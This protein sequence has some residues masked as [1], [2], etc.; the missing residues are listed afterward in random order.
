MV[1]SGLLR[2]Q[3]MFR[4]LS[5]HR[6]IINKWRIYRQHKYMKYIYAGR[7]MMQHIVVDSYIQFSVLVD[8]NFFFL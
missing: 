6:A 5:V 2:S 4:D 7:K 8:F 1:I 3:V